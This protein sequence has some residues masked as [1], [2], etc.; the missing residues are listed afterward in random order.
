MMDVPVLGANFGHLGFLCNEVDDGLI[1]TVA[2]ALAGDVSIEKR[3]T[4]RIDVVCDGD[5]EIREAGEEVAGPR[6]FFAVNGFPS[7]AEQRERSSTSV[8]RFQGITSRVCAVM[9]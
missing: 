9:V 6:S 2:A 8:T 3:S 5:D 7:L 4:L 1:A